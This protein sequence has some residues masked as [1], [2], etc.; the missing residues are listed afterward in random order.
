MG[1]KKIG[2]I[3]RKPAA[4]EEHETGDVQEVE[5]EKRR[6][7][8]GNEKYIGAHV[9]IQGGV[10]YYITKPLKSSHAVSHLCPSV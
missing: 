10:N 5:G 4:D 3:K 6:K 1:P 8:R 2:A 9:R 7:N